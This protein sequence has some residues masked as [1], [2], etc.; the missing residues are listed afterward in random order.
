MLGAGGTA[1]LGADAVSNYFVNRNLHGRYL[2]GLYIATLLAA[3][4]LP[5]LEG[6]R[7]NARVR[8]LVLAAVIAIHAYA[9]PFVLLR[10]F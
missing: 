4:T 6:G 3:W 7:P 9:L 2:V 5:L 10:Y 1:T 8:V